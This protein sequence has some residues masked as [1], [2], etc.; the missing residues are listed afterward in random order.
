MQRPQ[1]HGWTLWLASVAFFMVALD[2]L[3]VMTALPAIHRDLGSSLTSLQWTVNAYGISYAAVMIA[4]AVVG[5]LFGRRLVFAIGL[6]LFTVASA[7]CALSPDAST[8]IVSRTVQGVGAAVVTPLSLTLLTAATPPERR[9]A[10][11][12]IW[13]GIAGLAVAS[14]PLIG[15]AVTEGINWHWI[16]WLNV[17]IG[18]AATLLSLTKLSESRGPTM[19]LDLW[20]MA[21]V[22][23][24]A[25]SLVWGLVRADTAGWSSGEVVSTLVVGVTLLFLFIAWEARAAQPMLPLPLFRVPAFAAGNVVGFLMMGAL[26]AAAFFISQYFQVVLGYSP[27]QTGARLLPWTA[28]PIVVAPLAGALSDKIGHRPLVVAGVLLQAIGFGWIALIAHDRISYP[29]VVAAL[30]VAGV[31]IST[32]IPVVPTAILNAAPHNDLGM[33]SGVSSTMQRFGS[34]FVIAIASAVFGAYGHLGSRSAFVD[35]FRPALLVAAG[36]SLVGAIIAIAIGGRKRKEP[37]FLA[38]VA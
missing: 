29:Q 34:V 31:G 3:V 16:F 15:G 9:G 13:G 1:V 33:A 26:M 22:S 11:V 25:V 7:A 35:G 12:G 17:P 6:A 18:V 24:G 28:A 4:A 38:E 10:I 36:L 37:T 14:G 8:L 5:D 23:A 2:A 27:L 19:K 20:G 32:A 21:L 30:L